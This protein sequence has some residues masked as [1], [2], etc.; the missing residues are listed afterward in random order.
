VSGVATAIGEVACRVALCAALFP[1]VASAQEVALDCRHA[2]TTAALPSSGAL[3]LDVEAGADSWLE[4]EEKGAEIV[5]EGAPA[6]V[7]EVTVP[8]RYGRFFVPARGTQHVRVLRVNAS[9]SSAAAR[10]VLHCLPSAA[11]ISRVNWYRRAA[12]VS[13]N[14]LPISKGIAIERTLAEI[15]LLDVDVPD[16]SALA[17][18][19]HMRAQAWFTDNRTLESISAFAAAEAA[20]RSAGDVSRSLVARVGRVV[21]LN[22]AGRYREAIELTEEK[23]RADA[24][25]QYFAGRLGFSRCLALRYLGALRRAAT[26]YVHAIDAQKALGERAEASGLILALADILRALG[27]PETARL[28]ATEAYAMAEGPDAPLLRGRAQVLLYDILLD[29]G[30]VADALDRIED[31]LREFG[32]VHAGRWEANAMLRAAWT[33]AQFGAVEEARAFIGAAKERLS[34]QDAPARVAAANML[35]AEVSRRARQV[36]EGLASARAAEEAYIRL[37]M[38]LEAAASRSLMAELEL[39]SDDVDAAEVILGEQ[40]SSSLSARDELARARI[41]MA[42]GDLRRAR[43]ILSRIA[44]LSGSL[45]Q[46]VELASLNAKLLA[47]TGKI[48]PALKLV[49]NVAERIRT[50]ARSSRN[51]LL[52]D[53][54]VRQ[55]ASL[56]EQA[57]ELVVDPIASSDTPLTREEQL[58]EAWKWIL[59]NEPPRA[60]SLPGAEEDMSRFDHIVA[61]ELLIDP[62]RRPERSSV[63]SVRTLLA[64]IAV[65]GVANHENAEREPSLSRIQSMLGAETAFVAFLDGSTKGVALWVTAKEAWL[66]PTGDRGTLRSHKAELLTL[67]RNPDT[68]VAAIDA[69]ADALL[70]NLFPTIPADSPP[71]KLLVDANGELSDIPWSALHWRSGEE[72]LV[73]STDISLVQLRTNCCV[74]TAPKFQSRLFVVRGSQSEN[75]AQPELPIAAV[76]S[77]LI[78][79]AIEGSDVAATPHL[80][81]DRGGIFELL[82]ADGDWVHF[83]THGAALPDRIGFNGIWLQAPAASGPTFLSGIDVL[84]HKI[85]SEL[86]VLGT[87]ESAKRAGRGTYASFSFADALSRSGAGNVIAS[88]WSISDSAAAIWVPAFYG[89]ATKNKHSFAEALRIAQL[90][91]HDSR[92]FRHPFYW[93]SLVHLTQLEI[94]DEESN[95]TAT[96]TVAGI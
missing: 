27:E 80:A 71:K 5:L 44:S 20:W 6:S 31:A 70:S 72:A 49:R 79:S 1:T 63:D 81:I 75:T 52:A 30:R 29:R 57:I 32:S 94:S 53:L 78:S 9:A 8:P 56:R 91:L 48:R 74:R 47:L 54:L 62:A 58:S 22:R 18:Q 3:S 17:L 26:C 25:D 66:V 73:A 7:I 50:A 64:L 86:V 84:G 42:R 68:P 15:A 37:Q 41:A 51:P 19:A 65:D 67:I 61:S 38:P 24:A 88:L 45:S 82:E 36:D 59:L 14:L 43:S 28:K 87:C 90:R 12:S 69:S 96:T 40:H 89:R 55:V 93:S 35:A 77:L 33:Y 4:I 13:S 46:R 92:S 95:S 16:A 39:D 11:D 21:E 83:A 60:A 2:R 85:G 34:E 23:T 10:F 76:E